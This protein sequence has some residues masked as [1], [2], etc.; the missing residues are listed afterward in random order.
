MEIK[1]ADVMTTEL[2][3]CRAG[4]PLRDVA[5]LMV[6]NNISSV[7]VK[8]SHEVVGILTERDF[9]GLFEK[10]DPKT[11]GDIMNRDLLTIQ[12]DAEVI[13]AAKMMGQ[14]HIRHLL[15]RENMKVVGI[16]SLRDILLIFPESIH[17]YVSRKLLH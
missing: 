4:D 9:L 7:V 2:V 3:S 15:V 14:H 12:E 16:V 10:G 1:V 8:I 11:A 5:R 17:G 6:D 13:E